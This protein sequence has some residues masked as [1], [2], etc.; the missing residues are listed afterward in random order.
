MVKAETREGYV[1]PAINIDPV[2]EQMK[3]TGEILERVRSGNVGAYAE[4]VRAHQSEVWK[5]VMFGLHDLD[6]SAD[7]VQQA[8]VDAYFALDR[9]EEGRDFGPWV[10]GIARN[11][12]RQEL[13][14]RGREGRR[15]SAY[16]EHLEVTGENERAEEHEQALRKALGHCRDK[17]EGSAR[18]ALD[19]RY[20]SSLCFPEIAEKIGRTVAATRQLLQR[21]RLQLKGCI[22]Q[23]LEGS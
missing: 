14:R 4:L 8:F 13:R 10:R 18:E 7:L 19:L 20:Q 1:V 5:V 9:F 21:V 6:T 11:L 23:Q 12:V 16:R 15:Y 2:E 22:T 3:S 17:L